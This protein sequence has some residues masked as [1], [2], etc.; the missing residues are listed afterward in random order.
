MTMTTGGVAP[1]ATSSADSSSAAA[2]RP[3]IPGVS[4]NAAGTTTRVGERKV[5][6]R[7]SG[8]RRMYATPAA[9]PQPAA[10]ASGRPGCQPPSGL[11]AASTTAAARL[12]TM[13][14]VAPARHPGASRPTIQSASAAMAGPAKQNSST[15]PTRAVGVAS[16]ATKNSGLPRRTSKSGCATARHQRLAMCN[17]ARRSDTFIVGLG[18]LGGRNPTFSK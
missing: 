5:A 7:R 2:N 14:P 16:W 12:P 4:R 17:A 18:R 8:A 13:I 11:S 1:K 9:A 3:A 10:N 15:K 6:N